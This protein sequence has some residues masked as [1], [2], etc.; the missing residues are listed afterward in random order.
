MPEISQAINDLGKA[1]KNLQDAQA[2]EEEARAD[3]K[4]KNKAAWKDADK[5]LWK[6]KGK[7]AITQ[8]ARD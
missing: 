6:A 7:D 2:E 8:A 3:E 4:E 1:V 5:A